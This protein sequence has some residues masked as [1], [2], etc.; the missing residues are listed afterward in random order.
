MVISFAET[1]I[2][3]MAVAN[4]LCIGSVGGHCSA[5][6][7]TVV[8][9]AHAVIGMNKSAPAFTQAELPH[10]HQ[11]T[12]CNDCHLQNLERHRSGAI[13]ILAIQPVGFLLLPLIKDLY[14]WIR[15]YGIQGAFLSRKMPGCEQHQCRCRNS[16]C[17]ISNGLTSIASLLN[18]L[19]LV[20]PL[21]A[22]PGQSQ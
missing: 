5:N 1:A 7:T 2:G 19:R 12:K 10:T 22:N 14:I 18:L 16:L 13:V 17:C 15:K 8:K 11:V 6:H 4:N 3:L 20:T 9:T 21:R